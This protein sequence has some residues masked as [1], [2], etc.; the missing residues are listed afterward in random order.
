M[1]LGRYRYLLLTRTSPGNDDVYEARFPNLQ[2]YETI[3]STGF[4]FPVPTNILLGQE[5]SVAWCLINLK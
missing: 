3:L 5:G 1:Q 2:F 4:S